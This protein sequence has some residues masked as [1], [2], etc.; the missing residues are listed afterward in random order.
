M[1][2]IGNKSIAV[3][4]S[5][6]PQDECFP[7]H[8]ENET[9]M[10]HSTGGLGCEQ[11]GSH[12]CPEGG[13]VSLKIGRCKFADGHFFPTEAKHQCCQLKLCCAFPL[14]PGADLWVGNHKGTFE[15]LP[16]DHWKGF[17]LMT[18]ERGEPFAVN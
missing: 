15:M 5:G 4:P 13:C 17:C 3:Q 6:E 8:P 10:S 11:E 16:F 18:E 2:S 1:S 9:S 14:D 12:G 7:K